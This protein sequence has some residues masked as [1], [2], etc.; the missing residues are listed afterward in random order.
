MGSPSSPPGFRNLPGKDCPW[1]IFTSL[2]PPFYHLPKSYFLQK[3]LIPPHLPKRLDFL[4]F[5]KKKKEGYIVLNPY[6][7]ETSSH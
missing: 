5:E 6:T 4:N 3:E 2:A 1:D 7:L